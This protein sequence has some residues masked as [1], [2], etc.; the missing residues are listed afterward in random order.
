MMKAILI[1]EQWPVPTGKIYLGGAEY[2]E[3]FIF[4]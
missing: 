4:C 2:T 3:K 1:S